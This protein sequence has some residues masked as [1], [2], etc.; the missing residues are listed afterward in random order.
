[1]AK[2]EKKECA[3]LFYEGYWNVIKR[4]PTRRKQSDVAGALV[5][6]FFTGR[7]QCS[8]FKGETLTTYM[9]L[10]ERMFF[11]RMKAMAGQKGGQAKPQAKQ[12]A[13]PEAEP[14][15]EPKQ[16]PKPK[17]TTTEKVSIDDVVVIETL[18]RGDEI[19]DEPEGFPRFMAEVVKLFNATTGQAYTYPPVDV[20]Q[21]ILDAFKA[22]HTLD[23][24]QKVMD[25]VKKW[26]RKMQTF[27]GV[28]ANGKFEQ[29]LNR[30]TD[31]WGGED[32]DWSQYDYLAQ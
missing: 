8:R 5:E 7:S 22:G 25:D 32:R 21:G 16:T 15:A 4:L 12:Q 27:S 2:T 26:P 9:Q 24:V 14:E 30:P 20:R 31:D 6:A 28:F 23:D 3:F 18:Y 10:E 29:H 19:Q 17:T 13:E 1:M 11:S